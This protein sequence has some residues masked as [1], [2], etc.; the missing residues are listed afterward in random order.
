MKSQVLPILFV[1][2]VIDMIG[3]GMLTPILPVIFND[4]T[5]PFFMLK[6]WSEGE[7]L[8]ISGFVLALFGVMQF[9][10]APIL[11][12]LSDVYGR[13][14]ILL[15]GVVTLAASQLLFGFGITIGSLAIVIIARALGGIAGANFSIAQA[16]IA[17]VTTPQDRAKSF[18][19]IGAAFGLGFI[20]GPLIGGW[21]AHA[22]GSPSAPF[23]LAGML[24]LMNSIGVMFAL[25]ETHH[26]TNKE[27]ARFD[28]LKGIKNVKSALQDV[29]ARS[30]FATNF[31]VQLG[32][33]GFT[34]FIGILL[35]QKFGYTELEI[36]TF[37]GFVGFWII[38]T[39]VGILRFVS[40]Y[41]SEKNIIPTSLLI[42]ILSMLAY[43]FTQNI[44]VIYAAIPF[45]A[46][47]MGLTNV[48]LLALISKNVGEEKQGVTL[49][50]NSSVQA[51][52]LG[53]GP[54]CA[55]IVAAGIGIAA[56]FVFAA[57]CIAGARIVF[58]DSKNKLK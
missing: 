13:K 5:S 2:L 38:I 19:L 56:P 7:R 41:Y 24:G 52:A 34:S 21:F 47:G 53:I 45:V 46:I 48:N 43:A 33:S 3:F 27:M 39:Q 23:V 16:I 1:T 14:N 26:R 6:F 36:G 12:E 40:K 17:D 22:V 25:P 58:V 31:L 10:A 55:G 18:G 11:G 9:I 35:L 8:L 44:Y 28:I 4:P 57:L 32:F 37:F 15:A 49:G 50:L 51:L 42:L 54:L 29:Q 30:L 20:A